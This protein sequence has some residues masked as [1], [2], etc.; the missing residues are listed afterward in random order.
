MNSNIQEQ[1]LSSDT[2]GAPPDKKSVQAER[3]LSLIAYKLWSESPRKGSFPSL[4][5]ALD[6]GLK[7]YADRSIVIDIDQ[8]GTVPN[9]D[10][11]GN[12][13]LV[14]SNHPSII[15]TLTDVPRQSIISRLTDQYFQ[16]VASLSPIGFEA[17]FTDAKNASVSYRCI[18]LPCANDGHQVD[19]VL[20]LISWNKREAAAL[21]DPTFPQVLAK[22]IRSRPDNRIAPKTADTAAPSDLNAE[23]L[24]VSNQSCVPA[25]DL[26]PSPQQIVSEGHSTMA[27]GIKK[28][29]YEEKM[30]ECMAID[31]AL[32]VALVD[33]ST[34][35]ALATSGNPNGVDLTVA[36]AGNTNVTRAK[37]N[38]MKELGLKDELEDILITLSTQ[39]HLI[40]LVN[41]EAAKGLFIYL[42]LDKSKANLAMARFKLSKIE[43][44]LVV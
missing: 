44:E 34:G 38:V 13:L 3:R 18:L 42:M 4:K 15:K 23:T 43:Q 6:S 29:N 9:I 21:T 7:K 24:A 11:I 1:R 8:N 41:A 32:A 19:K 33:L 30:Q 10:F 35:M 22:R 31:G 37:L 28:M 14:E 17:E 12:S 40:R 36:A 2:L 20:G 39:F 27:K 5:D 16:V 26:P 25:R